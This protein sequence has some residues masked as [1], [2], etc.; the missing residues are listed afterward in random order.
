[1]SLSLRADRRSAR[2]KTGVSLELARSINRTAALLFLAAFWAI[3]G[4]A[5]ALAVEPIKISRD[6]IA[7]DLFRAVEIYRN[8][9]DTFQ[10]S[11]APGA[12]GTVRRIEEIERASCRA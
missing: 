7:L 6:D 11:T 3:L 8:Q 9:G 10:V 1:G 12:D 2:N 4:C 5:S